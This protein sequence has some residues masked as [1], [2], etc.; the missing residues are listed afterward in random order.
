M[1]SLK[2]EDAAA[3]IGSGGIRGAGQDCAALLLERDMV[4]V[5]AYGGTQKWEKGK[6]R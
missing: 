6:R 3:A 1:L 2:G 4:V 5:G